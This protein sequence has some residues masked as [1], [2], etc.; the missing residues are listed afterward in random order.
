M[1]R[2][3]FQ[4]VAR[5]GYVARGVVFVLVSALALFSGIAGGKPDTKSALDTLLSQPFGRVWISLVGIG[6]LGFVVWR[7]AQSLGNADNYK[8]D[9]KGFAV[10]A[11][12][13]GSAII[14]I[15]LAYY[16]F[17]HAFG[18]GAGTGTPG[19]KGL[20]AWTMSQPFGRYLAGAVG[21]GLIIGGVVTIT[22][23]VRRKYERYL[24]PEATDSKLITF[25]CVYG[26]AARGA[27][28]AVV[29][30]F[31]IYAAFMVNPDNAGSMADALAWLR[32]L[33][34]GSVIYTLA[35]VGLASFGMYNL[36]EGRYRLVRHP[37]ISD[38]A[39]R[40]RC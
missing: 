36:I 33:P 1:S 25:T 15:G 14:Y 26:L 34:F 18:F 31:F 30:G 19:E 5:T 13:F 16:A 7:M 10:R 2:S 8:P 35:A 24:D 9:A 20:A 6:L 12:L 17:A 23:G 27:L 32:Q 29:G 39:G 37:E 40:S 22:K 4:L 11:A 28:F 3:R 38:V 21:I